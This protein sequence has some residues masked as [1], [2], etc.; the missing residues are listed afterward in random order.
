MFIRFIEKIQMRFVGLLHELRATWNVVKID[1]K[2]RRVIR[3][4]LVGDPR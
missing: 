4:H 3:T 1:A 2:G